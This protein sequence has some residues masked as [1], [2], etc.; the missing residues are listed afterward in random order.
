MAINTFFTPGA[1]SP[2]ALAAAMGQPLDIRS[3]AAGGGQPPAASIDQSAFAKPPAGAG[4]VMPPEMLHDQPTRSS[5]AQGL[6]DYGMNPNRPVGSAFEGV[7]RIAA[8]ASGYYHKSKDDD[9]LR[10]REEKTA[11]YLEEKLGPEWAEM[12]RTGDKDERREI[13]KAG[14]A[15]LANRAAQARSRTIAAKDYEGLKSQALGD[16]NLDPY[17]REMILSP[18]PDIAKR[19]LDLYGEE[20]KAAAGRK[21]AAAEKQR[22]RQQRYDSA[23]AQGMTH[24]Q[25]LA[26]SDKEDPYRL[27]TDP[28]KVD[29]YAN[30]YDVRTGDKLLDQKAVQLDMDTAKRVEKELSDQH[31]KASSLGNRL[32]EA[33]AILK[34]G[35]YTGPGAA[36]A[37][38]VMSIAAL[39]G[40]T[41]DQVS[42]SE[43][44]KNLILNMAKD[45]RQGFAGSV[46]NWEMTQYMASVVSIANTPEGNQKILGIMDRLVKKAQFYKT[47]AEDWTKMRQEAGKPIMKGT[48][49]EAYRKAREQEFDAEFKTY[50]DG[51]AE[52]AKAKKQAAKEAKEGVGFL[53]PQPDATAPAPAA[54]PAPSPTNAGVGQVVPLGGKQYRYEGTGPDGKPIYVPVN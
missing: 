46:S 45:A 28:S 49:F 4:A 53:R 31:T 12:Y 25:A 44:L 48:G 42:N 24:A 27:P 21:N 50:M 26:Y 39:W 19:G 10:K 8:L 37:N 36:S 54:T 1:V 6:I 29:P 51:I 35:L 38:A 47:V 20:R 3:P 30:A 43:G 23:I 33:Q 2:A 32:S 52:E 13:A 9:L 5:F 34:S 14:R 18:N 40:K 16:K 15:E 11:T 22:E 7:G 41:P 17:Y